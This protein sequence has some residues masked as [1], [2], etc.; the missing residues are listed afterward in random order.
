MLIWNIS[1][2]PGYFR[3]SLALNKYSYCN[4]DHRKFKGMIPSIL[5]TTS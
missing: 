3:S 4:G 1:E 5:P 2:Q